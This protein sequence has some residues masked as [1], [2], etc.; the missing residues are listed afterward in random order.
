VSIPTVVEDSRVD[1]P[2][3][4]L[5]TGRR[6]ARVVLALATV[7]TLCLAAVELRSTSDSPAPQVISGPFALLLGASADLGASRAQTVEL[8]AELRGPDR[9][10]RLLQWADTNGLSVRWRTGDGWA[11]LQ[12]SPASFATAFRVAI[13]DYRGRAG[14]D[15]FQFSFGGR[16]RVTFDADSAVDADD[17]ALKLASA[18][19]EAAATV[20]EPSSIN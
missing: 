6:L 15:W 11:V 7:G 19:R 9:P 3:L 8:T 14:P 4:G 1:A 10:D 20:I 5:G 17:A 13:H 2:R 12:G 18:V 16:Q